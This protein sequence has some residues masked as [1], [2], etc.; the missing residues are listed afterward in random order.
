MTHIEKFEIRI[1]LIKV[2]SVLIGFGGVCFTMGKY[3]EDWQA[4]RKDITTR[5]T[6]TEQAIKTL[7][8]NHK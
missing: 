1:T 7:K 8:M 6:Q 2:I 3:M 5:V 4:W